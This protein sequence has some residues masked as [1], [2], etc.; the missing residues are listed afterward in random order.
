METAAGNI[1]KDSSCK[2]GHRE[3]TRKCSGDKGSEPREL[4]EWPQDT[5]TRGTE[6]EYVRWGGS[7]GSQPSGWR[8]SEA[9]E[10][11]VKYSK[12]RELDEGSG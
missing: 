3:G 1:C 7:A 8:G 5:Q 9:T 4:A 11:G 6:R 12:A 2:P 10:H